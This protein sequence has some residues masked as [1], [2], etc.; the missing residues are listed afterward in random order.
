MNLNCCLKKFCLQHG[1]ELLLF[2]YFIVQHGE[3]ITVENFYD[4]SKGALQRFKK[5]KISLNQR[6]PDKEGTEVILNDWCQNK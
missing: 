1:F 6:L 5:L 2:Q 3:E 4:T